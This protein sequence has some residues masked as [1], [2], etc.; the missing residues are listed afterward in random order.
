[1]Q[2]SFHYSTNLNS[3]FG[4][5]INQAPSGNVESFVLLPNKI[6]AQGQIT[7]AGAHWAIF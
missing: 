6:M 4:V 7:T 2:I 1:M 5:P 3:A